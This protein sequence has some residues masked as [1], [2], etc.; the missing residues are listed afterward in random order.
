[1]SVPVIMDAIVIF[2]RTAIAKYYTTLFTV[3][4]QVQLFKYKVHTV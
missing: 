2:L 1:M 4:L 3:W